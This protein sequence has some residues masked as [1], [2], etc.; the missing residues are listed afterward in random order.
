MFTIGEDPCVNYVK[1]FECEGKDKNGG[2]KDYVVV[3][4]HH[5]LS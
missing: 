2:K 4:N 1:T 5:Y 3:V